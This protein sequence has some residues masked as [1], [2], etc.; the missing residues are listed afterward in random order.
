MNGHFIYTN[1]FWDHNSELEKLCQCRQLKIKHKIKTLVPAGIMRNRLIFPVRR[2]KKNRLHKSIQQIPTETIN[3]RAETL[4]CVKMNAEILY[5]T[6]MKTRAIVVIRMWMNALLFIWFSFSFSFSFSPGPDCF[7]VLR[8]ATREN[9]W[10]KV[11]SRKLHCEQSCIWTTVEGD[12]HAKQ[13]RTKSGYPTSSAADYLYLKG[14]NFRKV[15]GW[16][17]AR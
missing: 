4:L 9:N 13:T 3:H 1:M 5:G 6:D 15:T 10:T 7:R 11:K 8:I 12:K 2:R 17:T 16:T 14:L